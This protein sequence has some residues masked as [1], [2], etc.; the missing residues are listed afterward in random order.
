MGLSRRDFLNAGALTVGGLTLADM[1]RLK[2][3]GAASA[4]SPGKAVIMVYLNGGHRT[5]TSTT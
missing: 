1:L 5:W 4:G 3:Q 2:A